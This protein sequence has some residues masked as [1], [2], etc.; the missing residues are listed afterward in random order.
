MKRLIIVY[1]IMSCWCT[2]FAQN[3][4]SDILEASRLSVSYI[5]LPF[6]VDEVLAIYEIDT[7]IISKH[8][9]NLSDKDRQSHLGYRYLYDMGVNAMVDS[10]NKRRNVYN[11][12]KI[13]KIISELHS[14]KAIA[15]NVD[16]IELFS[17]CDVCPFGEYPPDSY[18]MFK[19]ALVF[20][21]ETEI[22]QTILSENGKQWE[23]ALEDI[24]EG[25][26]YFVGKDDANREIDRR[27]IQFLIDKWSPC[28]IPEV[29]Q[30]VSVLKEVLPMEYKDEWY[31]AITGKWR[32]QFGEK[33]IEI[34]ID[35]NEFEI[36]GFSKFEGQPDE[37]R[38]TFYGDEY[39]QVEGPYV[40]F[41][42]TEQPTDK[43][44]NGKFY[45]RLVRNTGKMEGTWTSNNRKLERAFVLDKV[46]E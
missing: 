30:L 11:A 4:N 43:E 17:V 46:V 24:A 37:K 16:W 27:I 21:S 9:V 26:I 45:C 29:Q 6:M 44:W 32:G 39:Q 15:P 23:Y 18:S 1:W 40:C 34:T 14:R 41:T 20:A 33:T 28:Q 22:R 25:S 31:E 2:A 3:T 7:T 19:A 36:N 13:D 12:S 8:Y 10:L 35:A 38:I 42:V 5:E